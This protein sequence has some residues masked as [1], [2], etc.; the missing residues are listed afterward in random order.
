MSNPSIA[1]IHPSTHLRK[2]AISSANVSFPHTSP[3]SLEIA[4]LDVISLCA[5]ASNQQHLHNHQRQQL[6][7]AR[8]VSGFQL[9]GVASSEAWRARPSCRP[10]RSARFEVRSEASQGHDPLR[11]S[12]SHASSSLP[13]AVFSIFDDRGDGVISTEHIPSILEKL[14]RSATEGRRSFRR[15][16]HYTTQ[17]SHTRVFLCQTC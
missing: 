9:K 10:R 3:P 14:G 8:S 4:H 5:G 2:A 7:R 1:T 6:Q 12:L 16:R 17:P 15:R 11:G 13:T